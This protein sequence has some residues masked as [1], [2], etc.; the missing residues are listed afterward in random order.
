LVHTD[1]RQSILIAPFC[2]SRLA[3]FAKTI[4]GLREH[5]DEQCVWIAVTHVEHLLSVVWSEL[6]FGFQ[7]DL[8][9][10]EVRSVFVL[11]LRNDVL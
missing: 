4:V 11:G 2:V 6:A 5:H 10:V 9:H 7:V 8:L 3:S 1:P